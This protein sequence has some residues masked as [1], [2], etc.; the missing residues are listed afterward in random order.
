MKIGC[1]VSSLS[2]KT[3][4]I[5][6]SVRGLSCALQAQPSTEV[7]VLGTSDAAS[8]KDLAGWSPLPVHAF[9][10]RGSVRFGYAP[11]L[12][13]KLL[14]L[15]VD[16][17]LTHG[18][19]MYSSIVTLAW[20]RRTQRPFIVHPHGMLDPWAMNQ[21]YLKKSLAGFLY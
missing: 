1:L 8:R 20:H 11:G 5:F 15:D 6:E 7:H 4:G 9:P 14:E 16:I 17:L 18:L 10:V 3:G 19:W 21:S 12:L 13:Q 2:P